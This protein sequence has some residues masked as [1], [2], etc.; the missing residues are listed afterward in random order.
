M[1]RGVFKNQFLVPQLYINKEYKTTFPV[2]LCFIFTSLQPLVLYGSQQTVVKCK[3][4]PVASLPKA[5]RCFPLYWC[6][7][8]TVLH[9]RLMPSFCPLDTTAL[10]MPWILHLL[11]QMLHT[12]EF[13]IVLF[14]L[15]LVFLLRLLGSVWCL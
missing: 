14:L 9:S 7:V 12:P 3:L 1:G 10:S 11:C 2:D 4:G 15:T 6:E 5:L 13:C 8:L